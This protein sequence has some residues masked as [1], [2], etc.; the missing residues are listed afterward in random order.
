MHSPSTLPNPAV[1]WVRIRTV[2]LDMDGTLLDLHF[3]NTFWLEHVPARYAER[4]RLALED[5]RAQV[6]QRYREVEG[7]MQWYCVDY[8]TRELDLDIAELKQEIDHLIGV[9]PYAEEFLHALRAADKR[10]VLVTNA[11]AKSLNLKLERTDLGRH[12]DAVVCAHDL[13]L[14]KE[15]PEFWE[16]LREREPFDPESTLLIDDSPSVLRS[17]QAYGMPHLLAIARPD[18]R[19]PPRETGGFPAVESFEAI[20]PPRPEPLGEASPAQRQGSR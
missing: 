9:R 13:G 20:L 1:D 10:L 4:H 3:D 19:R 16:R 18:S 7:T 17:A 15:A 2:L 14:P 8:W 6:Y 12:F 11:H 5:A